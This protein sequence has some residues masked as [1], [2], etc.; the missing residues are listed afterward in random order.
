MLKTAL[1]VALFTLMSTAVNADQFVV[2]NGHRMMPL[3]AFSADFGATVGYDN[4]H[5]AISIGLGYN[6]VDVIPFSTTAWV[7][8]N[9]VLLSEPVVIVDGV[10]YVP[11][12]FMCDSFGLMANW[13]F[14]YDQLIITSPY[15]YFPVSFSLDLAFGE[16]PHFFNHNYDI[17][18][19]RNFAPGREGFA[20][21]GRRFNPTGPRGFGGAGRGG[22]PTRPQGFGG[23]A[24]FTGGGLGGGVR[25]GFSGGVRGGGSVR[26]FSGGVRGGGGGRGR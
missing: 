2:I 3:S 1:F 6:T 14:G 10:T 11:V 15:T 26:G 25:G 20:P 8:G 9:A 4:G 7:N 21:G 18:A 19:Y 16:R 5:D 22:S 23:R 17:H 13:D 24:P 12:L